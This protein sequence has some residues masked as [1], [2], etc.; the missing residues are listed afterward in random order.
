[1]GALRD[2]IDEKRKKGKVTAAT[3][4]E[5]G[6]TGS[7]VIDLMDALRKSVAKRG[8]ETKTH[9]AAPAPRR[10][11]SAKSK[12]GAR[13]SARKSPPKRKAG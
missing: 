4:E 3:D 9:R 5:L 6:D 8:G 10:K 2:L 11:S 12:S 13:K 7:N 1:M